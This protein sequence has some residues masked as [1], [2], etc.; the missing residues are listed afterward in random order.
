MAGDYK[1]TLLMPQTDFSMRASLAQKEPEIQARWKEAHVYEEALAQNKD[2]KPWVLHDGPPYANGPIHCGHAL[3]KIIKDFIVRSHTM[4]GDYSPYI[5]GWD[6]HG[7]PIE[8]AMTKALKVNRKSIPTQDFRDMCRDYA[9]KQVA[10]Q[11]E[12]FMR[13]GVA[14]DWDHPYLTLQPEYEA[15]QVRAFGAMVARGLIFRGLKPVYWSW[16]SE[17]ALAE[18][19]V[20]Y[21]DVTSKTVYV[22]FPVLDG[23]GKFPAG[24]NLVIWTTTPWTLPAN[25]A[26]VVHPDFTYAL[27]SHDGAR[28][29]IAEGLLDECA[30]IFGWDTFTREAVFK[31]RDLEY[32][33]YTNPLLP[34]TGPVILGRH[35]TLDAGTG[36]IH[37]APG[38]GE[39]D[40]NVGKLYNR[41]ITVDIDDHGVLNKDAG[42]Y[43]GMFYEDA[44]EVIL[45]DL[46]KTGSALAMPSI[47]HAYPFDWRTKKPIVYRATEQW[48]CSIEAIKGEMLKAIADCTWKPLWGETRLGN[49]IK[50]RKEWCISRQRVWGVPIPVFYAEDGTAILDAALIAHVADI[51]AQEGSNAWFKKSEAELLPAGYTNPHSPHGIFKKETDTMDV[52]FDSGS[53]HQDVLVRRGEG[54]PASL[55]FEG[56][57][58][59]RG[60]FNSSLSVGVALT[61]HAPY[62]SVLSHG[63]ILD[64]EGRKM[65]KSLGNTLDPLK[66]VNKYGADVFRLWVSSVDYTADVRISEAMIDNAAQSYRKIRNTIKF[67]LGNLADFTAGEDDVPFAELDPV[68]KAILVTLSRLTAR[69]REDYRTYEFMDATKALMSFITNDLSAF[70]LDYTK[71]VLYVEARD[72]R[73]RRGVQTVLSQVL[74]DLMRLLTPILPHTMEEVHDYLV[75]ADKK[76]SVTLEH[77]PDPVTYPDEDELL[78]R[79]A[80]LLS[81]RTDVMKALE[82]ARTAHVIGK[83]LEADVCIAPVASLAQA[84]ESSGIDF[85]KVFI[86]ARFIVDPLLPE[87]NTTPSGRILVTAARGETCARCWQVVPAVDGRG[88]CP[89]CSALVDCLRPSTHD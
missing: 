24:T 7:L 62:K 31:G 80:M 15:M 56:S 33:T 82:D 83:S 32:V 57:D 41:P 53:S 73:S 30:R 34:K 28:Y 8:V 17:S 13:L 58:Q 35:A 43:Q 1:D 81:L 71:D 48:F 69:V 74:F 70:Y 51:F 10:L 86:V 20:E 61:N 59:Y 42:P 9:L 2:G 75:R 87:G 84:L 50:E 11:K 18:A 76:S 45:S 65:S 52:W 63:F 39:D 25:E 12:G 55:Y 21:Q 64:G 49:M 44:N 68:D 54:Y 47:T 4:A 78:A 89:R 6:T 60:W 14:G 88:L 36:L 16:S 40:F 22:S 26:I 66:I 38:L 85:K 72:S 29:V 5:P 79:Y 23:K 77:F 27:V 67:L 19:E 37:T 3:N 46:K